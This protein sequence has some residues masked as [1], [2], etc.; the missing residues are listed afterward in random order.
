MLEHGINCRIPFVLEALSQLI[1]FRRVWVT[2]SPHIASCC[3]YCSISWDQIAIN[4]VR[5]WSAI[6]K[7]SNIAPRI[8]CVLRSWGYVR[9]GKEIR[10]YS[11]I[12]NLSET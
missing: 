3:F 5:F 6:S 8:L 1:S 2:A 4:R 11:L 12:N 9:L 7:K 10:L